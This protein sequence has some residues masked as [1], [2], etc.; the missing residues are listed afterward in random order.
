LNERPKRRKKVEE[1]IFSSLDVDVALH[2][3]LYLDIAGISGRK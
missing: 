2:S 3:R 1:K